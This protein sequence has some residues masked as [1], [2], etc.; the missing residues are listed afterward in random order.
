[1]YNTGSTTAFLLGESCLLQVLLVA[2][3]N[4]VRLVRSLEMTL[5]S[6]NIPPEILA[7]LLNLDGDAE[8]SLLVN[9]KRLNDFQL[10]RR[11][12]IKI[13]HNDLA[14]TVSKA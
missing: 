9:L 14:Q 5:S 4:L 13:F 3:H 2:G 10:S 1:M 12:S 8:Y 11:I 7:T 6:P